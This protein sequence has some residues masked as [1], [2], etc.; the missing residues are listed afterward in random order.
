MFLNE[1]NKNFFD[2]S[3]RYACKQI[4]SST[5]LKNAL[6]QLGIGIILAIFSIYLTIKYVNT[7]Q[8]TQVVIIHDPP[9]DDKQHDDK[10]NKQPIPL[11]VTAQ[12]PVE[13]SHIGA[14]TSQHTENQSAGNKTD[15]KQGQIMIETKIDKPEVK[16]STEQPELEKKSPPVSHLFGRHH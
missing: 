9:P 3:V 15:V 13:K 12:P 5:L 4:S 10:N 7:T 2:N 6:V 14:E 1:K 11:V 8:Q 16:N